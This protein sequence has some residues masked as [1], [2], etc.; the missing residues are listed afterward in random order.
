[1]RS[2]TLIERKPEPTGVV[3]GPLMPT[4]VRLQ[5]LQRGIRERVAVLA[6]LVDA[7]LVAVPVEVDAGGLEDAPGG[8]GQLGA[9]A[10]SG[11]EGHVVRHRCLSGWSRPSREPAMLP[12]GLASQRRRAEFLQPFGQRRRGAPHLAPRLRQARVVAARREVDRDEMRRRARDAGRDRGG[13]DRVGGGAAR[14]RGRRRARRASPC[15]RRRAPARA[16]PGPRARGCRRARGRASPAG[17]SAGRRRAPRAR[18]GRPPRWRRRARS[19]GAPAPSPC[20]LAPAAPSQPGA[21][22]RAASATTA[23]RERRACAPTARRRPRGRRSG[24]VR[25]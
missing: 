19:R 9:G 12:V 15:R 3:V 23:G 16:A 8:L 7:G 1:M 2:S 22:R 10:V 18:R 25:P 20:A 13:G 11:D 5:R 24:R 17:R 6:V 4:P 21:E 14:A